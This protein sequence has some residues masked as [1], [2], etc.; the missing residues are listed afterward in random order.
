MKPLRLM[1]LISITLSTACTS[2]PGTKELKQAIW[3]EMNKDANT[4]TCLRLIDVKKTD[5]LAGE[6]G[7]QKTYE[8]MWT[9]HVEAKDNCWSSKKDFVA[10]PVDPNCKGIACLVSMGREQINE[11]DTFEF[12]G[13]TTFLRLESGWKAVRTR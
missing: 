6:A 4:S 3:A 12:S 11:G 2:D 1:A 7:G 5:G 9:A 8:M 13:S 10:F